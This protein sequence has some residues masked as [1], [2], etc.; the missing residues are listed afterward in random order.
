MPRPGLPVWLPFAV[1]AGVIVVIGLFGVAVVAVLASADASFD[2]SDPPDWVTIALTVV[3]DLAFVG[4]AWLA[5]HVVQGGARA[6]DLGLR[7][8][9][10]RQALVWAAGLYGAFWV[11]AAVLIAV[12]GEPPE[13][14]IVQELRRQDAVGVLVG[15]AVLTCVFAP[16]A[17]EFFF[18]GFMFT[19]FSRRMGPVWASLLTGAV[20][21]LVHAPGAPA[22]GV[23]VLAAFGVVLCVLYW[24]TGSIIPCMALHAI[25][26]SISF[27]ATKSLPVWG[28]AGLAAISV[29]AVLAVATAFARP[30]SPA[31]TA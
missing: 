25:H 8:V 21:G 4:A 31:V 18:R 7:R 1:L 16:F 28:W 27:A 3:Q 10:P 20:F 24:R 9:S 12:F 22:L 2:T 5:V 6:G 13:Q 23:A 19:V 17:E 14:D 15:Y 30:A 11:L 26:N 29:G